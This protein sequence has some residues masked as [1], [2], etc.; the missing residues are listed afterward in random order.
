MLTT[1]KIISGISFYSVACTTRKNHS[2]RYVISE[3]LNILFISM[4]NFCDVA[5]YLK[6][7]FWFRDTEE[8]MITIMIKIHS[9]SS[10]PW[11]IMHQCSTHHFFFSS[12]ASYQIFM[13]PNLPCIRKALFFFCH[14]WIKWY[15]IHWYNEI[16]YLE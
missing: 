3:D 8:N 14:S 15:M 7:H 4:C 1:S 11:S 2:L 6:C 9:L 16:Y 5:C 10:V 12:L 13:P